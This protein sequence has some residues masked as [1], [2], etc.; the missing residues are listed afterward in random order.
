MS[1][2]PTQ[3]LM[4]PFSGY[5]LPSDQ[6]LAL[7]NQALGQLALVGIQN[8]E[9]IVDNVDFVLDEMRALQALTQSQA[10][11]LLLIKERLKVAE[12]QKKETARTFEAYKNISNEAT[13]AL[14]ARVDMLFS[15][16]KGANAQI[17]QLRTDL[18]ILDKRYS[19]HTHAIGSRFVG[20]YGTSGYVPTY[21]SKPTD[22]AIT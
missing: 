3:T 5:L 22:G 15:E 21:S 1:I 20:G 19:G 16:L 11:E 18:T 6:D 14:L 13:V 8:Q 12:E 2:R 4:T 7:T 9:K 17:Q 10:S